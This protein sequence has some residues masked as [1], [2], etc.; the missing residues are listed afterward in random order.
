MMTLQRATALDILKS[1]VTPYGGPAAGPVILDGKE[2]GIVYEDAAARYCRL[3]PL[4]PADTSPSREAQTEQ[5][6]EVMDQALQGCGMGFTDIVR[7]WFFLDGLLDWYGEFNRVR[8]DFFETRGTFDHIVPASTGIGVANAAR[9]ALVAGLV[10]VKP[11]DGRTTVQA[12][13]S[14]LQGSAMD[15]R[16]SFSRA[17]EVATPD[18]RML[19]ISGTA[20]IDREGHSVHVGDCALQIQKTMAVVAAIL[21]SRQMRWQDV[22]RG[23]VYYPDPSDHDR[24]V[25]YCR[26]SGIPDFPLALMESD[27]CRREL[28]FEIELNAVASPIES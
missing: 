21:E 26:A 13:G 15:Y 5:V 24:Y 19:Y 1:Q 17:V 11:K 27:V 25:A 2:I 14:P 4:V 20:S 12:V 7:T 9:S 8:T 22:S 6:F 16:S 28:L 10:A 3:A 23:V 18:A